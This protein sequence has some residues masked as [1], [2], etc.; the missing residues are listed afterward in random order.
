[1]VATQVNSQGSAVQPIGT[2]MIVYGT[3]KAESVQG[4]T[5]T[6]QPNSPIFPNDRITTGSDGMI[7]IVFGDA[8]RTQLDLG[9]MS[10]MT[11]DE[12]VFPGDMPVD[13]AEAAMEVEQIQQALLEGEFDPTQDL[14][15]TAAGPA[16]GAASDGGGISSVRFFLTAEEVTPESGAET[17]GI[18]YNFLDP[19]PPVLDLEPTPIITAFA[20]P[21]AE[22]TPDIP[23]LIPPPPPPPP[24]VV[25]LDINRVVEE[26]A[27][28]EGVQYFATIFEIEGTGESTVDEWFF[29]VEGGSKPVSFN[30]LTEHSFPWQSEWQDLNSDHLDGDPGQENL[31]SF[32]T[33]WKDD[34]SGS[35]TIPVNVSFGSNPY[36]PGGIDTSTSWADPA[37]G[38]V[39]DP[40]EY[41]LKIADQYWDGSY[42]TGPYQIRITGEITITQIPDGGYITS[43]PDQYNSGT[44]P[45]VSDGNPDQDD[46]IS[47]DLQPDS[48]VVSG[49]LNDGLT[50]ATGTWSITMAGALPNLVSQ[51]TPIVYFPNSTNPNMIEARAYDYG[52]TDGG[53]SGYRVVFTFE[54][55]ASGDYTFTLYD[56]LDN[57]SPGYV[58]PGGTI[59]TEKD[60]DAPLAEENLEMVIYNGDD[61]PTSWVNTIDFSQNLLLNGAQLFPPG[62]FTIQSIDD[63]PVAT[64]NCGGI[65]GKVEEDGMQMGQSDE[66]NQY[67]DPDTSPPLVSDPDLST[68]AKS[69]W[70]DN[71]EDEIWDGNSIASL[72]KVGADEFNQQREQAPAEAEY[73]ISSDPDLLEE[74]PQLWSQ[75]EQVEYKVVGNTLVA[76]VP[77]EEPEP[78]E[79][80]LETVS[81]EIVNGTEDR[82][83]FTL[84]VHTD[85]SWYFDLDDQLDHVDQ[86]WAAAWENKMLR[87]GDNAEETIGI[88]GLDFS[89]ILT[90]TDFDGD[91]IVGAVPGKFVL[92]I[93][94]DIPKVCDPRC[95]EVSESALEEIDVATG[96]DTGTGDAP[97]IGPVLT[98]NFLTDG[99]II[100]GSDEFANGLVEIS[101]NGESLLLGTTTPGSITVYG[102]LSGAGDHISGKAGQLTISSDGSWEYRLIDNTTEHDDT[103][104]GSDGDGDRG[105]ADTKLDS[106]NIWVTDYDGDSVKLDFD[107][108]VL[109]D[110]PKIEIGEVR[111][112]SGEV[113]EDALGNTTA[114]PANNNDPDS[115]TGNL[116]DDDPPG[117]SQETDTTTINLG[118]L[119]PASAVDYG[120]DGFGSSQF[121]IVGID[122]SSPYLS[123]HTSSH[124]Q[125]WYFKVGNTIEARTSGTPGDPDP[126]GNLIFTAE[127]ST[128]S[129]EVTFNL[130]DQMDHSPNL[131]PADRDEATLTI[132]DL[133]QFIEYEVTDGDGDKA[134]VNFEGLLNIYVENDVPEVIETAQYF[135]VSEYAGYNN[136]IGTYVLDDDGNPEFVKLIL[137]QT[138]AVANWAQAGT[139]D[140]DNP[141]PVNPYSFDLSGEA[142]SGPYHYTPGVDLGS[143]EGGTKIFIVANGGHSLDGESELRFDDGVLQ[144]LVNG[145]WVDVTTLT[146]VQGVY[147]M[148]AEFD[149]PAPDYWGRGP[150]PDDLNHFTDQWAVTFGPGPY[151]GEFINEVP[152]YGGEVRIEDLNFGDHD[153]DDTVLRIEKGPV[154]SESHLD[155]TTSNPEDGGTKKDPYST[156]V[157]NGNF[158]AASLAGIQFMTGADEPLT[159]NISSQGIFTPEEFVDINDPN[160]TNVEIDIING[161][162]KGSSQLI[163]SDAGTLEIWE[164]GDWQYTLI[165]NTLIH[166]DNDKGS[167]DKHDGDYDR[168]AADQVQDV[169]AITATDKD[170]DFV[171]TDF[172]V[173]IND[174][175]PQIGTPQDS[176]MASTYLIEPI[177]QGVPTLAVAAHNDALVPINELTADLSVDYG[178]DG[179]GGIELNLVEGA[180]VMAKV[181]GDMQQIHVLQDGA[182]IWHQESADTW[183]AVTDWGAKAFTVSVNEANGTYSVQLFLELEGTGGTTIINFGDNL[184]GGNPDLAVFGDGDEIATTATTVTY[185]NSIFLLAQGSQDLAGDFGGD[186]TPYS[187]TDTFGTDSDKDTTI[188]Y[189][190]QGIGVGGGAKID[191]IG[192]EAGRPSEILSLKF[193]SQVEVE[194][195]HKGDYV[196]GTTMAITSATV[197]LDHIGYDDT[198]YFSLWKS[199]VQVSG[200]LSYSPTTTE[201]KTGGGSSS[202][203]L[204]VTFSSD[205]VVADASNPNLEFDEIR[206]ET[207]SNY[208]VVAVEINEDVDGFDQTIIIPFEVTD[209]DGDTVEDT[210]SITFDGTGAIDAK[211][212]DMADGDLSTEGMVISGSSD[213]D[214]IIGTDY[215]DTVNGGGGDDIISG[216]EGN[217]N[218]EGGIGNDIIDGGTGSDALYGDEGNDILIG[219]SGD[220]QLIGGYGEDT[221]EGNAGNDDLV[222]DEIIFDDTGNSIID[223]GDDDTVYGGDDTVDTGTADAGADATDTSGSTDIDFGVEDDLDI[224]TLIPPPDIV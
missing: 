82:V 52:M 179:P 170:G 27:M 142:N 75:G 108:K 197:L 224:D 151:A 78:A 186:A 213:S 26:E 139:G 44:I 137:P 46:I 9:R 48:A 83:V 129:G 65:W 39:L 177:P 172:I 38:D 176:V 181:D 11:I 98:G 103:I 122:E 29:T 112:L 115:S 218:L 2:A 70:D 132:D 140:L 55:V 12:D 125:I 56:Q 50:G 174:D 59:L 42:D 221:L 96:D 30:I 143:Y 110:G 188:N 80:G 180:K 66:G 37:F 175:G 41:V 196:T 184:N 182:L 123:T 121:S 134:S 7:S 178:A 8:A 34:G 189:S 150:A 156:T 16:A 76:Y 154:V 124:M 45:S 191:D 169:F 155:T 201:A 146:N 152:E 220:D 47:D 113:Q 138:N 111:P 211:E 147:L 31:N 118:S 148:D 159:L 216:G 183:S 10:D 77:G 114:N 74:L 102:D 195:G 127:L 171:D 160:D 116:D 73:G 18:G 161:G 167:V 93:E 60:P 88:S 119:V 105:Y 67:W 173:N 53:E 1:M 206:F 51:G 19:D 203:D 25:T 164:N 23:E 162:L 144:S 194:T 198:A 106:F 71:S 204:A 97:L 202:I 209:G 131:N 192:D 13:I 68:G 214:I 28:D 86:T 208:R 130:N 104:I 126:S 57:V 64:N 3:V 219:D 99:N 33:L 94:D 166:P 217:D 15:A 199:G 4:I 141:G 165:D 92:V 207:G 24:P 40:G 158:F 87:V 128:T 84:T 215:D 43:M 21:P 205:D 149:S 107:V 212:A 117:T 136:T 222:G 91:T 135:Y 17:I 185:G 120:A 63:I 20:A 109:D 153:F 79:G 100:A 36:G 145:T 72:F 69:P 61:P 6:L 90:A 133:G 58:G 32:L 49:N 54:V 223:D 22:P 101:V 85:G 187:G 168:Y 5:R 14:E 200:E 193:L 89:S 95:L 157:V 62:S 81:Q 190:N 210:F 163:N 35:F